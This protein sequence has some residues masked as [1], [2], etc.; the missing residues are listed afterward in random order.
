MDDLYK[1][2]LFLEYFTVI[3]N[4]GEAFFSILFGSL[5]NSIALVG[6]G[7]DSVVESLSGIILIWRLKIHGFVGEEEEYEIE[8]K[9]TKLVGVTF[10]ILSFYV[11][12]ESIRKLIFVEK[13]DPSVAGIIIALASLLIMPFLYYQKNS[14]G[15][16]IGSKALIADSKET[17][18]C[19]FLSLPLFLGL[20]SNYFFGL[21]Q[22]D[23][24][25]GIIIFIFLVK[26]GI[27]I[28]RESDND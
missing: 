16:K 18:A 2:G 4:I 7:L 3:Y 21:W 27:E 25:V 12:I 24:I 14:I 6:F 28:V 10:F 13:S 1:K 19:A 8:K 22:A 5:S 17:L 11:L 26:E 23:S 15:A 9:A 20:T